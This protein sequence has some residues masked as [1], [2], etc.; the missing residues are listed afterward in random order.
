MD[1]ISVTELKHS[2]KLWERL[3]KNDLIVTRD[4]KPGAVMIPVEAHE[5]SEVS[6]LLADLRFSRTLQKIRTRVAENPLT[7]AEI[8]AEVQA[9]RRGE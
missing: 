7:E 9:Y 3:A 1:Y 2:K 8:Q 5:V 4:G 6:K